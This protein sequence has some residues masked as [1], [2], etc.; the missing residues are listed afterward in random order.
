MVD[1][2]VHANPESRVETFPGSRLSARHSLSQKQSR[3]VRTGRVA[4]YGRVATIVLSIYL[5][6]ILPWGKALGDSFEESPPL[7]EPLLW[8][9]KIVAPSRGTAQKPTP[10]LNKQDSPVERVN[11][12][13]TRPEDPVRKEMT[14]APAPNDTEPRTTNALYRLAEPHFAAGPRPSLIAATPPEFPRLFWRSPLR[15][16][17]VEDIPP[18]Y[19]TPKLAGEGVWDTRDLPTSENGWPLMYKTSY[20]P[21]SKYPNAIVH[22]L[23]LDM[24]RVSMRLYIGSSEPAA[25]KGASK[26][27]P[28]L[29]GQLVAIT[30]ALWKQKHA[31]GAGAIFR[32]KILRE[33]APG[34]ASLVVYKDDSVDILEWNPSIP[35]STIRDARQLRHLIVKDGKVV[36]S[37]IKHGERV[38]SEIGLGFLLAEGGQPYRQWWG[39]YYYGGPAANFSD[40]WFIA[41][42]SAFGVRRDGN[43][44][45]AIGHHIS[46]KDLAKALVL[47]GCARAIHA[48]ANP[49][50]VVANLYYPD[51]DGGIARKER[52]S[53]DQ[54]S[55]T[56]NRYVEKSYTSDFFAFYR[57]LA[58]GETS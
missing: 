41:T 33:M 26:I 19:V 4:S 1:F 36:Q 39:G 47:A 42:R 46:T 52:L 54:K 23:L 11:R 34:M 40:E 55:Y 50:N 27:E 18:L 7:W 17:S 30:N 56:L 2:S 57:R 44:V 22:M 9:G 10:S 48:D 12:A 51:G 45:F 35:I 3:P 29:K 49:H 13:E 5:V 6:C 28:D 8:G 15:S 31:R 32:G 38:D 14:I 37:V 25:P 53:P 43:L 16:L 20:R 58:Q 21:S 24:K